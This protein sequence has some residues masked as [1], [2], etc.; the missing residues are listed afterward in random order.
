[1]PPL[2]ALPIDEQG[3]TK[4]F[5]I[6]EFD[7]EEACRFFDKYGVIVFDGV[8]DEEEMEKTIDDLWTDIQSRCGKENIRNDPNTWKF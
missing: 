4:S 6:D 2:E 7:E 5:K 1:M 3:F 8:L